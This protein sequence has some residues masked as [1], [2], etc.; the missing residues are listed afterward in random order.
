MGTFQTGITFN[1]GIL[2]NGAALPNNDFISGMIFNNTA[3]PSG[4]PSSGIKQCLSIQDAI[5]GG[6]DGKHEDETAATGSYAITHGAAGAGDTISVYVQEPVNPLNTSTNPNKVLL[7]TYTCVSGDTTAS[8]LATNLTNAINANKAANGGYSASVTSAT[9]TVT[10]RPGLGIALNSGTPISVT[11]TG[12]TIAG[13]ITQ[14]SDGVGSKLDVYYYHISEFFRMN[15]IGNLWVMVDTTAAYTT[16]FAS[17]STLQAAALGVIRQ[18]GIYNEG[19]TVV[20]DIDADAN[21]LNTVCQTLDTNKMPLSAVLVE[22][23]SAVTDLTTLPNLSLLNDEWVSVNISQD[24]SAQGWTLFQAYGKT[25]SNLG[26]LLGCISAVPVSACIAQPIP[27]LNITN[28]T[29]NQIPCFGNGAQ[30]SATSITLQ[31]ELDNYRYIYAGNYVGYTGTYFND[32]HCAIISNS[33]YA[34]IEENRVEAKI[35]R[36]LYSAYL[37]LLKSQ[38]QLNADGTLFGPLVYSLESV[39][40]NVLNQNM[41]AQGELS[42]VKTVISATQNITASGKLVVTVNEIDNPVARNIQI[43]VNSVTAL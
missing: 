18:V 38:L 13:T 35:E 19:R 20:A 24:G 5:N 32:S 14:F 4:W 23:M 30:F 2:T 41:V 33:N 10:A 7:V 31:T 16:T 43:N 15:P 11:I 21:A 29:E 3:L 37:P 34:Y 12:G 27:A 6:I 40:D 39:G 26:A 9:V 25:I 22:D 1:K 28:G 8:T 36:L 42:A 17:V